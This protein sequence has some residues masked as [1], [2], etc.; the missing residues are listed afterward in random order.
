MNFYLN[1]KSMPMIRKCAN[2]KFYNILHKKCNKIHI[3]NAYDHCKL[4]YL[5]LGD[6]LY[7][8]QHQFNNE[9]MLKKNAVVVEYNS[10]K[11]A[12]EVI[13]NKKA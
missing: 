11:D 10:V 12:M 6:N 9:D 7:C 3:Y 5:N 4:V 1:K 13:Q 8:E 2:C